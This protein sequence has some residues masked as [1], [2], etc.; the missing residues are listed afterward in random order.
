MLFNVKHYSFLRNMCFQEDLLPVFKMTCNEYSIKVHQIT[1]EV[2]SETK[3]ILQSNLRYCM[4]SL[5][6][7]YA[8]SNP[9]I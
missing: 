2:N 5:P 1:S 6:L 9:L 3:Y 7:K 8:T 4:I